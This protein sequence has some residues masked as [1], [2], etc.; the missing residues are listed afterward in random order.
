MPRWPGRFISRLTI[1]LWQGLTA[2]QAATHVGLQ[3]WL[4]Q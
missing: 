4:S 2:G 3:Q 1:S